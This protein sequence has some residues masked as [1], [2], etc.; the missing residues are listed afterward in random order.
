MKGNANLEIS[1]TVKTSSFQAGETNQVNIDQDGELSLT[2]EATVWDDLVTPATSGKRGANDKPDFDYDQLAVCFPQNDPLEYL[3]FNIQLTHDWKIGSTIYPH[4]HI[5]QNQNQTPVFKMSYRW[6][7]TGGVVP[8]WSV[9]TMDQLVKT[10]TSGT[11]HQIVTNSVGISGAGK[12]L[13]S[14]IQLKLFRQDNVYLGDC[15]VISF[16]IHIEKD[17]LGSF[18][19]YTKVIN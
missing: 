6:L 19:E 5:L 18:T 3:H 7:E 16:D 1:G 8:D 9:Y 14:I 13:S 17:A 12:G 15:L 11:M 10:Y 4:V 2:G